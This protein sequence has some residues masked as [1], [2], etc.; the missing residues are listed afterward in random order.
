MEATWEE[1]VDVVK[2]SDIKAQINGVAVKMNDF[3]FLFCLLFAERILKHTDNL[4]KTIQATSMSAVE[5]RR[6]SQLCTEVLKNLRTDEYFNQYWAYAE[7][8][9]EDL[10][11][12]EASLLSLHKR[13]RCYEDGTAD[14]Y[15]PATPMM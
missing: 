12:G 3:H 1:A 9:Q 11:I 15:H 10:N 5:G 7:K 2:E 8:V 6:L 13:P 4:S 14:H